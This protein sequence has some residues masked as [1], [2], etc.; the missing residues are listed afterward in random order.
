VWL[1]GVSDGGLGVLAYTLEGRR[2]VARRM[3]VSVWLGQ[4]ADPS[5]LARVPRVR[6]GGWRFFQGGSDRLYPKGNTVPWMREFCAGMGSLQ[7]LV[8]FDAAGEHDWAWWRAHR[9]EWLKAALR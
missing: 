5:V 6:Q 2:F 3:L 7:C 9:L 8:Q 4:L 1:L